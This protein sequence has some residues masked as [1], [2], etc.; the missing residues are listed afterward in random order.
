[1]PKKA[2]GQASYICCQCNEHFTSLT[3]FYKTYS[4]LYAGTGYLPICKNC[5]SKLFDSYI[6][7]YKDVRKAMQRICMAFDLYYSDSI[8]ET[9]ND[10]TSAMLGN[11]IKRLNMVQYKGRTF[12]V[13][14]DEGFEFNKV[15]SPKSKNIE[16]RETNESKEE[17]INPEDIEK[18]G[19]G[20]ENV[21]YGILNAHYRLLKTANP[22]C[23]SNQEIFITDLCYTKM[24]QMKAVREGR[25]D[26][27]NKL[28][29]SYRKSF[30]QAGL[31]TVKDSNINEE[32]TIGVNAETIEK[33]T[34]AEYYKDK[35]LYHDF[36]NIGEYIER[37]L[38]RPLRNLM[39]GTKDRD[40]E[41]FV[42]DEENEDVYQEE[43]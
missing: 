16:I 23:D 40:Y 13:T 21:D 20:F 33:Y 18:W 22:N 30:T 36:D 39:H 4:G 24:Q 11:Y 5:F 7:K 14:L 10:G 3:Q 1:M 8:F 6:K 43:E 25:V 31:K 34:P 17:I 28:T 26:D 35:K 12:D 19:I 42:K 15:A 9:C 29:D 38:L 37:F 27:Y 32:F 2:S 41:Y